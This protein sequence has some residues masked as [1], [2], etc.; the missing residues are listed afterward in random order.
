[1]HDLV[2]LFD[3]DNTLLDNDRIQR[4]L[5]AHLGLEYRRRRRATAIGRCSR[6]CARRLGYADYLG[7][8][9]RYRLEDL[10]DPRVLRIAN[11]LADYPF[12][13][14]LYPRA[15]DAV[16]HAQQWGTDRHPVRRRRGVPAAQGG[17]LRPVAHVRQQRA[18]LRAQGRIAGRR[19][20]AVPRAALRDGGRQA[21]D[22]GGAEEAWGDRVTTVFPARATTRWSPAWRRN[23][24]SR[25]SRSRRSPIFWDFER[26]AFEG[27]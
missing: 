24:A 23:T 2:F 9:Q 5:N 3:V 12:A 11:W 7:A 21:A 19:R 15:L 6:N 16:R 27:R 20:A 17:T 22:P 18:D 10:H 26:E 1:M 14:R 25:T 4:D 13:A 8:L